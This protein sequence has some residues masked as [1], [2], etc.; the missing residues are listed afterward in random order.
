MNRTPVYLDHQATTPVD[1]RVLAT[2]IEAWREHQ[3][4][5]S[6]RHQPGRRAAAALHTARQR[7]QHSLGADHAQEITFTSGAT[8]ANHLAIIGTVTAS[9]SKRHVITS[10]IEHDSVLNACSTLHSAGHSVT[11]I[12]VDPHGWVDPERIAAAI[13]PETALI[14]IMYANNEIGT[15]QSI[16]DI[17]AVAREHDV[18]VHV[19]AAQILTTQRVDVVRVGIDLLTISAHKIY[20]P[21]GT[22]AL[23]HRRGIPI[24]PPVPRQPRARTPR[25]HHESSRSR[26]PRARPPHPRRPARHRCVAHPHS[27][28]PTRRTP[29]RRTPGRPTQRKPDTPAG[30]HPQRHDSRPRSDRPYRALPD[31]AV[32]SGSACSSGRAAPSHVLTAIGLTPASA[33]ATLRIGIGRQTLPSDIEVAAHRIV[34]EARRAVRSKAQ[35]MP[36]PPQQPWRSRLA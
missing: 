12:P 34:E 11:T 31:V 28:G 10:A 6:S 15:I 30:R 1:P 9:G 23:Y 36:R 8:E 35:S 14:S 19:D 32:S 4:N 13:R 18:L 21:V 33:R 22:G 29:S 24:R 2:M 16:A 25:R 5:P 26:R 7:V 20:G 17:V 27:A 3:A